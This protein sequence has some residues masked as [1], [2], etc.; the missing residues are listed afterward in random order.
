MEMIIAMSKTVI[1]RIN[2]FQA[3]VDCCGLYRIINNNVFS[4][5]NALGYF[6]APASTKYHLAYEG[7]LYEHSRNV[8]DALMKFTTD[9]GLCWQRSQSPYIVG[10]FHDLCKADQYKFNKDL[11]CWEYNGKTLY[12]GHGDKS[13]MLLSSILTLTDEEA[14]CIRWHMGAFDEKENWNLYS[15]AIHK[16]PNVL[17]THQADMYATHVMEVGK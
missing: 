7:G 17:W 5:I 4:K 11:N 8:A 15:N 14:L 1:D 2:D 6:D 9:N 10:F 13:L 3:Y 12:K 16:Y